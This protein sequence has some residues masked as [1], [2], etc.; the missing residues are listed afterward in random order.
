MNGAQWILRIDDLRRILLLV[1]AFVFFFLI[2][3]TALGVQ[4]QAGGGKRGSIA[5][6]FTCEVE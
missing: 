3:G 4:G 6:G 2:L 1:Q 5:G